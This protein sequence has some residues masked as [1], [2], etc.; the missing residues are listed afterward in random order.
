M[1]ESKPEVQQI[2]LVLSPMRAAKVEALNAEVQ[3]LQR[4]LAERQARLDDVL[5]VILDGE[6]EGDGL[7]P[8]LQRRDGQVFLVVTRGDV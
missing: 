1:A 4:A 8:S 3:A 5:A 2:E 6:I 7:V